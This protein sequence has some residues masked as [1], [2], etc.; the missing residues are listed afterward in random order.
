MVGQAAWY[1][2]E[3]V[4]WRFSAILSLNLQLSLKW[5]LNDKDSKIH[6]FIYYPVYNHSS[7]HWT[8]I[9]CNLSSRRTLRWS[10]SALVKLIKKESA[11]LLVR[12]QCFVDLGLWGCWEAFPQASPYPKLI[13]TAVESTDLQ[14]EM[15][16]EKSSAGINFH[17]VL[18]SLS[19]RPIPPSSQTSLSL[20]NIAAKQQ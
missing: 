18:R 3:S 1:A 10:S 5:E 14:E 9:W 7:H 12:P 2:L 6:V 13:R 17:Y 11:V 19:R 16:K 20:S 4:S 8:I 15:A